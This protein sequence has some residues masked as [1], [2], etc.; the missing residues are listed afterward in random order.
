MDPGLLMF[1]EVRAAAGTLNDVFA[2]EPQEIGG[3]QL[4]HCVNSAANRYRPQ[5]CEPL[6]NYKGV[7][8]I[9]EALRWGP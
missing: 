7:L 6:V 3:D 1:D 9:V 8:K 4:R 2:I 5:H